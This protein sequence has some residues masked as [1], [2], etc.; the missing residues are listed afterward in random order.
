[1][2]KI[3]LVLMFLLIAH[4][5]YG[6]YFTLTPDGFMSETKADYVV[7]EVPGA[8]KED[9]YKNVL[10]AINSLYS[11]PQEGLSVLAGESITLNAY[12]RKAIKASAGIM[13]Y[14]YDVDYT[15]TFLFKDG[16]IRV[17]SPTFDASM[18]NYNGTWAKLDVSRAYFKKNGDPKS[19][20]HLK[21]V[22][23]LFNG[24]VKNILDK[25]VKIDNW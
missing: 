16:K 9:L 17:N 23:E 3:R 5:N 2:K 1:M 15:L 8:K 22:N 12:K 7:I 11:H 6:Q 13:T 21:G 14:D 18:K 24:F 4:L 20:K 19:E 25:S 10:N